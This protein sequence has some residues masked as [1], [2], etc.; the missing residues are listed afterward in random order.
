ME[1]SIRLRRG[2]R[3]YEMDF[4]K[5]KWKKTLHY[6]ISMRDGGIEKEVSL[7]KRKREK[8]VCSSAL[9]LEISRISEF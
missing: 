3:P 9:A 4:M 8:G 1:V 2:L 7:G 6:M 5:W